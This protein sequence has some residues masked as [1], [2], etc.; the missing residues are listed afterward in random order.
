MRVRDN[1]EKS[2]EEELRSLRNSKNC[3]YVTTKVTDYGGGMFPHEILT[4]GPFMDTIFHLGLYL[5]SPMLFVLTNEIFSSLHQPELSQKTTMASV[6]MA[7]QGASVGPW[8]GS[9]SFL[10]PVG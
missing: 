7:Q 3:S 8:K 1:D 5:I 9:F 6:R 4:W 2:T 10:P